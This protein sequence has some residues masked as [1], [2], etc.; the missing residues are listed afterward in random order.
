MTYSVAYPRSIFRRS[1]AGIR[2]VDGALLLLS[3]ILSGWVFIV[4][5]LVIMNIAAVDKNGRLPIVVPVIQW[6]PLSVCF[7]AVMIVKVRLAFSKRLG[8]RTNDQWEAFINGGL[9]RSSLSS[10]QASPEIKMNDLPELGENSGPCRWL[11][12]QNIPFHSPVTMNLPSGMQHEFASTF[13]R[14]VFNRVAQQ[15]FSNH[16]NDLTF[17][18]IVLHGKVHSTI[19]HQLTSEAMV[20]FVFRT[21]L[22]GSITSI[23][24]GGLQFTRR[25]AATGEKARRKRWSDDDVFIHSLRDRE[26]IPFWKC[27]IP[28]QGVFHTIECLREYL[29][30]HVF[31]EVPYSWL[32]FGE[33][34]CWQLVDREVS[35]LDWPGL[36]PDRS[37]VLAELDYM[38]KMVQNEVLR[39]VHAGI[40]KQSIP[41]PAHLTDNLS[42]PRTDFL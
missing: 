12:S 21:E 19:F 32:Q 34:G 2:T 22:N 23:L 3:P 6:L 9:S 24:C 16:N 7:T 27:C 13:E 20:I 25:E 18:R 35:S 4:A 37:A 29:K 11:E 33:L 17:G 31:S 41:S 40:A 8:E 38:K 1:M 28:L 15:L 5:F 36:Q 14:T 39:E 10:L 26:A 30:K 42:L